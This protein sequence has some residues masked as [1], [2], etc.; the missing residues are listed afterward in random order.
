MHEVQAVFFDCKMRPRKY[1]NSLSADLKDSRFCDNTYIGRYIGGES[2]EHSLDYVKAI[3][4]CVLS[5][6]VARIH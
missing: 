1:V 6:V 4:F 2:V 5:I 3:Y